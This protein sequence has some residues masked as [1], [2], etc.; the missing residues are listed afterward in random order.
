MEPDGGAITISIQPLSQERTEM[1][2]DHV[3]INIGDT[4]PGMTQEVV[5]RIF[6][7]FYTT[8]QSGTGLGLAIS[9]RIIT[10]HRGTITVQSWPTVGTIFTIIL[11]A[12]T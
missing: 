7:P 1:R 12:A 5:D 9:Q 6:D 4:G 11:P 3:S 2:G 10:A 8:K